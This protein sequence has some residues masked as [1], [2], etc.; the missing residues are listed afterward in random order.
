MNFDIDIAIVVGFL[1]LTLIIGLGHGY[2]V[3]TMEQYALGGRNFS[4]GALIATIVA[5]WIG[6]GT[7]FT[8]LSRTYSDG[9]AFILPV[10]GMILSFS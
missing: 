7:F 9:L 2:K 3:Q 4:T 5:S 6:G 1:I 8:S 10:Y